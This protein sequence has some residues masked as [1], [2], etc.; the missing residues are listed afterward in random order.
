MNRWPY[1]RFLSTQC[2]SFWEIWT[3]LL[4]RREPYYRLA[5]R[6]FLLVVYGSTDLV[7]NKSQCIFLQIWT[8]IGWALDK[9]K[10]VNMRFREYRDWEE[11][12][13]LSLSTVISILRVLGLGWEFRI[14]LRTT[15]KVTLIFKEKSL[16][17]ST[18]IR[19]ECS[20]LENFRHAT[21]P[22][23]WLCYL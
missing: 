3:P 11:K 9:F 2:S 8:H 18:S 16:D 19:K 23:N 10:D 5:G 21:H 12:L 1:A 22:K 7:M 4:H 6:Q 13:R 15:I 20:F 14:S 17:Y